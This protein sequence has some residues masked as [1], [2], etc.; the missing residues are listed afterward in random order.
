MPFSATQRVR[1][2]AEAR[3]LLAKLIVLRDRAVELDLQIVRAPCAAA[4]AFS[5]SSM[6]A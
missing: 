2:L 4:S 3:E 1:V 5:L 6:R